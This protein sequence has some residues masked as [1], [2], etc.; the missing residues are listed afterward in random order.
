MIEEIT[1]DAPLG[2]HAIKD[3]RKDRLLRTKA[4]I[5]RTG[6]SSMTIRRREAA[7]TFPKRERIGVYSVA[8]YE[9]DID[10]FVADPLGYRAP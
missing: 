5:E 10:D 1:G 9:S 6:L 8:W 4:V 7:G 2:A 3:R